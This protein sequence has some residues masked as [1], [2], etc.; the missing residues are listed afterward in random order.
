MKCVVTHLATDFAMI[1]TFTHSFDPASN[2]PASGPTVD[3]E[4][5][6]IEAAGIK[7]VLQTPGAAFGTWRVLDYA[8]SRYGSRHT[9]Y[10][11]RSARSV[12]GGEGGTLRVIRPLCRASV[13]RR[14][15][16]SHLLCSCDSSSCRFARA[17]STARKTPSNP[18]VR[19][20]GGNSL[21]IGWTALAQKKGPPARL[22]FLWA[23]DTNA[24]SP[25]GGATEYGGLKR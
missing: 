12:A 2:N 5:E 22:V 18:G 4:V 19:N 15:P 7:E 1:C 16:Q 21:A 11:P 10:F 13:C 3:L 8:T 14:V 25:L 6:A 17:A 20:R 24:I 23:R 9:V